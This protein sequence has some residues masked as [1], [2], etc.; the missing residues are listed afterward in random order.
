M[1]QDRATKDSLT[2]RCRAPSWIVCR[3]PSIGM[4]CHRYDRSEQASQTA[5]ARSAYR[6]SLLPAPQ[7]TY[8]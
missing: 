3:I 7:L 6:R 8:I 1:C 5:P 2:C 4:R